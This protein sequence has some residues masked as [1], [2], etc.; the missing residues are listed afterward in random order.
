MI[1]LPYHPSNAFPLREVIQNP[2]KYA[3]WIEEQAVSTFENTP[4]I[5]PDMKSK[6][7]PVSDNASDAGVLTHGFTV[8]RRIRVD[9]GNIAGCAAGSFENIYAV[10]A[11]AKA[12]GHGLGQ[13]PFNIYPAS[14]PIMVELNRVGVMNDLMIHGVRVKTAFCGPCFGASDCPENNAFTIRHS[15]RNFP[16]FEKNSKQIK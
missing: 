5:H 13:F 9:Q 8:D 10:D 2:E 3:E 11:V 14:Q 1:A 7:V 6:I 12:A 16:N 4:D 15:T